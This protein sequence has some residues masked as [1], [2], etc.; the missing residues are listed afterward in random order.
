MSNN[1]QGLRRRLSVDWFLNTE[2]SLEPSDTEDHSM[3]MQ[4][5]IDMPNIFL[6]II[7]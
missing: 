1:K 4:K 5:K 6:V 7:I 2:L 3:L